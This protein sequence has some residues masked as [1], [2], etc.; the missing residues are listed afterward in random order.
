MKRSLKKTAGFGGDYRRISHD[1]RLL[2]CLCVLTCTRGNVSVGI[3]VVPEPCFICT[4]SFCVRLKNKNK[5][6]VLNLLSITTTTFRRAYRWVQEKGRLRVLVIKA[7]HH[8]TNEGTNAITT[9][10]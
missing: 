4:K 3:V 2:W 5:F 8:A 1:L 10:R 6:N 7:K 9:I